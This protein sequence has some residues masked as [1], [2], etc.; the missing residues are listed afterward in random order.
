MQIKSRVVI[1]PER[2]EALAFLALWAQRNR[3]F[4]TRRYAFTPWRLAAEGLRFLT[5]TGAR[6]GREPLT[7][8][9]GRY[10]IAV[11]RGHYTVLADS[12]VVPL[13][14][15][16]AGGGDP[17][18]YVFSVAD[19]LLAV[20]AIPRGEEAQDRAVEVVLSAVATRAR[21]AS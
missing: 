18:S 3:G 21:A 12:V 11:A 5:A 15:M 10:S 1:S 2:V 6:D 8:V 17:W 4:Q 13:L 16:A 20:L 14:R 9:A 19:D 7:G